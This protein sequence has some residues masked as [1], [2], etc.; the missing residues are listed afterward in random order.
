MLL[1]VSNVEELLLIRP[2]EFVRVDSEK[3]GKLYSDMGDSAAEDVVCRAM[4]ELALRLAHCDRLYRAN[5]MDDLRKSSRSLIAIADQIGMTKL[6]R[7][8]GDV[9]ECIDD[10]NG[11]ALAATL[12]RLMRI[13][14]G[15]LTAIWDLQDLTI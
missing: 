12:G 7:V 4:E 2:T 6:A 11:V 5:N 15:S 10:S 8:A 1:R 14:E 3:L 13:G 9:T